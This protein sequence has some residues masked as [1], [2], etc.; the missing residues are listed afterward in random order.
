MTVK[1]IIN[2]CYSDENITI[3]NQY[4]CFEHGTADT[5]VK[6]LDYEVNKITT[7][8]DGIGIYINAYKLP[9]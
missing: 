4:R 1:E 8:D 6:Y 2:K 3:M 7:Y 5:I 9:L